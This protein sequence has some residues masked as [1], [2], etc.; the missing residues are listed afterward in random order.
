[1]DCFYN[2]KNLAHFKQKNTVVVFH[3]LHFQGKQRFRE[4]IE[5]GRTFM[6]LP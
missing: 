1:M 6:A 2:L 3:F 4:N 5:K